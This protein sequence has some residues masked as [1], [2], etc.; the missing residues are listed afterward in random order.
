MKTK[1]REDK[2]TLKN[3]W[4]RRRYELK[5]KLNHQKIF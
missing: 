3:I 5:R 1:L 2:L 4:L